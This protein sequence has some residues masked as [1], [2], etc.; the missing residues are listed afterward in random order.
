METI[1]RF[2]KKLSSKQLK[3]AIDILKAIGLNPVAEEKI[4]KLDEWQKIELANRVKN[5]ES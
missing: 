3:M 1:L 5:I 4:I 2:N